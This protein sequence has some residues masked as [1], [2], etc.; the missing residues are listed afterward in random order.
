MSSSIEALQQR[1]EQVE[2]E[3]GALAS[4]MD[5][6]SS[7]A[8]AL[9]NKGPFDDQVKDYIEELCQDGPTASL[10]RHDAELILKLAD[11]LEEAEAPDALGG[12]MW[13][14][15]QCA[16]WIREQAEGGGDE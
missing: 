14:A 8:I 11:Q 5:R 9:A 13:D 15:S 4:H 6:W 7:L 1:L 2:A 10:A 16:D 12:D 3:R